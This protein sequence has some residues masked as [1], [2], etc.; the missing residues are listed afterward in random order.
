MTSAMLPSAFRATAM[1]APQFLAIGCLVAQSTVAVRGAAFDSLQGTPL[2]GAVITIVGT[3]VTVRTDGRGRFSF[4][5][6]TPGTHTFTAHHAA[7]DSLG[8]S[9]ISTRAN[10]TDG[11][12]DVRLA[13]PSFNTLWRAACGDGRVPKDSGFIYGTVRTA[14]SAAPT[15]NATV[16]LTWLDLSVTRTKR[17]TQSRW[18]GQSVTTEAGDYAICGVPLDVGLRVRA[19]TDSATSGLIDLP[20]REVRVQRRDL[21]IG[22]LPDDSTT[23]ARGMIVGVVT[24]SSGG[25]I[26]DARVVADGMPELRTDSAGRFAIRGVPVGSRQVEVLAIGRKPVSTVVDV[27]PNDTARV[28]ASMRRITTLDVVRV[29]ASPAVRRLVRDLEER[30][31]RGFG[32][33]RDSTDLGFH[34]TM[35]SVFYSFPGVRP[36]RSRIGASFV[37]HLRAPLG[38]YC[39]ANLII[40]GYRAEFEELDFV[41]PSDVAAVE[42]YPRGM[43]APPQFVRDPFCGAV[44]VWTKWALGS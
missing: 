3:P 8:F 1:V 28:I 7:L 24:D 44:V 32:Y 2:A 38:G 35:F 13:I 27:T 36:A 16:E 20:A 29:T 12:A 10:V 9:G 17:V 41:R 33:V 31:K 42:V 39:L 14:T 40:D 22:A 30:R 15:P 6:V 34:G 26:L 11:G 37:V 43:S 5:A 18:R 19:G 4:D 25:P 21:L 23:A